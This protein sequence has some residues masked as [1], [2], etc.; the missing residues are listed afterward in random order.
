MKHCT[1]AR[2]TFQW[3]GS[4]HLLRGSRQI[5]F[6]GVLHEQHNIMRL[7]PLYGFLCM[8]SQAAFGCDLLVVAES[9]CG[10]EFASG[11]CHSGNAHVWRIAKP[12][13]NL[14]Q[15]TAEAFIAKVG[16]C[17]LV[18]EAENMIH[19]FTPKYRR[20]QDDILP[21]LLACQNGAL[22]PV[23][24]YQSFEASELGASLGL[25]ESRKSRRTIPWRPARSG[26]NCRR[27]S[28]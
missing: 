24:T 4:A 2:F 27:E 9:I 20:E 8:R 5:E 21:C 15:P 14:L 22:V 6:G 18:C 16:T 11:S 3:A 26:S 17:H 12:F 13:H 23:A 7:H 28:V 10:L 19:G 1:T 25:T